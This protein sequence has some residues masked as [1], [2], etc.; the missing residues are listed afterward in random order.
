MLISALQQSDSV[1]HAEMVDGITDS[2]DMNMSKLGDGEGQGSLACWSP[3]GRKESDTTE[4]LKNSNKYI[5]V[6]VEL[7]YK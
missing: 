5:Y 2:M 4:R 1:I 7:I 3:W 6:F